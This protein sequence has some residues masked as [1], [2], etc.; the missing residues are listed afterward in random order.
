MKLIRPFCCIWH[1]ESSWNDKAAGRSS[2]YA[3]KQ[4]WDAGANQRRYD[5]FGGSSPKKTG[6]RKK[7][8]PAGD[9]RANRQRQHSSQQQQPQPAASNNPDCHYEVLGLSATASSAEIKKSYH[10]MA[11]KYHPDK[12]Q[13]EGAADIFRRVKLAYEVLGDDSTRIAY[14]AERRRR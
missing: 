13:E 7:D 9:P 1:S 11:R 6:S 5:P 10:K 2:A 4:Q 3:R 8:A 14:D 12:N